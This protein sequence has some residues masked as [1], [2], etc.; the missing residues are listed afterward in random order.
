MKDY[1]YKAKGLA[2][3]LG[4]AVVVK[5][6]II[7]LKDGSFL[8]SWRYQGVDSYAD[9]T[10]LL[11]TLR[12]T[13]NTT[14][15]SL[16]NG[17]LL[18]A[19]LI[20]KSVQNYS[21][22][23]ENY[24]PDATSFLIDEERRKQFND[25]QNYYESY[26]YFSLSYKPPIE[27]ESKVKQLFVNESGADTECGWEQILNLFESKINQVENSLSKSIS[28]QRLT[29]QEILSYLHESITGLTQTLLEPSFP[30]YLDQILATKDFI[31][32]LEPKIDSKYVKVIAIDGFPLESHFCMLEELSELPIAFRWSNRFIFLDSLTAMAQ[33]KKYR[34]QWF[35][36][37][38]GLM[39]LLRDIF[40][41]QEAGFQNQD[42]LDMTDDADAALQEAE[43]GLLRYGYY[44]ST[45][46]LMNED[47]EVL[48]DDCKLLT[49]K[50]EKNGFSTR[51]ETI[52]AV[53]AYI[54]SLPG[55]GYQNIRKP[56]IS[57][58]NLADLLPLTGINSGP[59]SHPC[60]YYPKQ[61]PPLIYAETRGKTPYRF[62]LHVND[63]GHTLVV[64]DTGSGKSTLLGFLIAQH[65]RYKN[66]QIFFFDKGYSSFILCHAL[67]G[68]HYDIASQSTALSFAPLQSINAEDIDWA[69]SWIETLCEMQGVAISTSQRQH[70]N[71]SLKNLLDRKNKTLSDL[72]VTLQDKEL[73]AALEFY[74]LSGAMGS[75]LDAEKDDLDSSHLQ[76]FEMQHLL[77][78][79]EKFVLPVLEYLFHRINKRLDVSRP[80][81]IIIE[82][83]HRFLKGKFAQQLEI[84]LRECRKYNTAVVF[85]TQGLAEIIDS[86]YKHILLNSCL[87]KIFLPNANAGADYNK[88]LYYQI[89]LND[90]QIELIRT[91][92]PKLDYYYTS[93]KCNRLMNF[94]L[95]WFFLFLMKPTNTD[96]RE[97]IKELVTTH[98]KRWLY[99]HLIENQLNKEAEAWVTQFEKM[100][101][102]NV[103]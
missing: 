61:S 91:A 101:N 46:I 1:R 51:V 9:D 88:N 7:L 92:I 30:V 79:N 82:E 87:T 65:L 50:L 47:K 15:G 64:G 69:C 81:L 94:A 22:P 100:E 76:V 72:Q 48:N 74:T 97:H 3:L 103:N 85:V 36:K 75:L 53:E 73:K 45:F 18:H 66:A 70:I 52:N 83:G 26:Y 60:P 62:N 16:D 6:G 80:T 25:E 28:L 41:S 98:D 33:L 58:A 55:H 34:R 31:G 56:M 77:E 71:E 57:I 78:R 54:G 59:L 20:R 21:L 13:I 17:W 12:R 102:Q 95:Y 14:L 63:V 89:G 19:D 4:Y 38:Q 10:A 90:S 29:T 37:R 40:H 8:C 5:E 43:S 49:K 32:G 96:E 67:Q 68:K 39:G 93:S 84:W 86:P 23:H 35:Q 44:T 99:H 24:F 2:D 11:E 27:I 42:A